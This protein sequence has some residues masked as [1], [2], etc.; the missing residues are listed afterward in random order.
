VRRIGHGGGGLGLGLRH[1]VLSEDELV[2]QLDEVRGAVAHNN[3]PT[4]Q[5]GVPHDSQPTVHSAARQND[6]QVIPAYEQGVKGRVGDKRHE[7]SALMS[8]ANKDLLCHVAQSDS[9]LVDLTL[10]NALIVMELSVVDEMELLCSTASGENGGK[11]WRDLFSGAMNAPLSVFVSGV[12]LQ[13]VV[14]CTGKL[15]KPI[16]A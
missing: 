14:N 13:E 10:I 2:R 9:V 4:N 15:F 8:K 3:Q 7:C 11:G 6:P 12:L 5:H 1:G 16:P